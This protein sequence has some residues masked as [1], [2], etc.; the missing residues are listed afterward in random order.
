[1]QERRNSIAN[2]LESHLSCTNTSTCKLWLWCITVADVLAI[3]IVNTVTGEWNQTIQWQ[4][5]DTSMILKQM[6]Q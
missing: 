6:V 4:D 3:D 5:A 2:A 1:M